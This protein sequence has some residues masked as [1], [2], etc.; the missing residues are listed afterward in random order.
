MY[1]LL[2]LIHF[3]YIIVFAG[4]SVSH[5]QDEILPCDLPSNLNI[6]T[7]T[8]N[9]AK[10]SW[11]NNENVQGWII[12]WRLQN[13]QYT[14][15]NNSGLIDTNFYE[16]TNIYPNS[17]YFF[18]IKSVC[19]SGESTWSNEYTFVTNLTNPS[20][21]SM[22]LPVKDPG[23]NNQTEKTYF[24][25][26]NSEFSGRSLGED[27]FIQK[28]N[29]I[30]DHDWTSD[31]EIKLTSPAGRSVFLVK[32]LNVNNLKGFGNPK[33]D[34]CLEVMSFSDDACKSQSEVNDRFV[35]DFLP[36]EQISGF[37]DGNS[38][39]G[40]WVIE[41]TDKVKI[42][43]GSLEYFDI[44]FAPVI[45]PIPSDIEIAPVD[46]QSIEIVWDQHV[47]VDTLILKLTK[48]NETRFFKSFNS[49]VILINDLMSDTEYQ[50]SLQSKCYNYISAYS[51]PKTIRTFCKSPIIREAFNE[52][53]MCEDPCLT[54]CLRSEFWFNDY[55]F[56]KKWLVNA[57]PTKTENTGP[58]QDVF[59]GGKYIY[60]E[61]SRGECELD[62]IATLQSVCLKVNESADGCDMSFFYHMYG[63]D[64]GSL[65]L[66]IS[67]NAG[68]SWSTLFQIHGNQGN[69]WH[70]KE[71]DL[72]TYKS[73]VCIFRF[74]GKV[75]ND[76]SFGDL[77]LDDITFF[78]CSKLV[79]SDYTF[80]P[81]HDND[82]YG[83][84]TTGLFICMP[85]VQNYV[86]NNKDCNDQN[87]NINPEATEI[88]CNFIDENCNGMSDDSGQD[89]PL[90]INLLEILNVSC[91]GKTDGKIILSVEDGLPPYNFLWSNGSTDSLLM[92]ASSGNYTCRIIDKT[93]CG[94]ITGP[95]FIGEEVN[96]QL[97]VT[98]L[99]HTQCKGI[100]S[101]EIEVEVNNGTGPYL[102]QWSN[103][104]NTKKISGLSPGFYS[105]TVTGADGCKVV[106][107]LIEIK[108]LASF[109]VG[110]NQMIEP[111]CYG[112]GNGTLELKVSGGKAPYKF[113]WNNGANDSKITGI[114]AGIYYCTITDADNCS[115]IEGP[116]KLN[117]PDE[118]KIKIT[119]IDNV[120][121]IGEENGSIEISAS[122]GK[123][124]YSF[125][126]ISHDYNDFVSFSDDIYNLRAGLYELFASDLNG[127]SVNLDN[128]EIKT[129]DSIEAFIDN[130]T[131]ASC[132]R[133]NEG[134]IAVKVTKGYQNYYY[135]WNNGG[136]ESSIDSL[137][138]GSYSVTVTDDL[139]CKFVINN[140]EVK[141]LDMPF[142]IELQLLNGIR[143][144]GKGDGAI[145]AYAGSDFPPFDFNWSAG[146]RNFT[147]QK[148]DSIINLNSGIYNVTVTDNAGCVGISENFVLDEPPEIEI[149]S[150]E[151]DEIL[152]YGNNSGS[153]KLEISGGIKPYS[154]SWN[155]G[156]YS[157]DKISKLFAG[158]YL[159]SIKDA[160]GCILLG[161][162]VN[163]GQP[164]EL[165]VKIVTKDAGKNQSNGEVFLLIEG[166]VS[167][168]EVVWDSNA[169]NQTGPH[170]FNL[171]KGWYS[172]T[173][174]DYNEC[175]K[176]LQ[177]Y[178]NENTVS[179]RELAEIDANIYPNPAS[180]HFVIEALS[181]QVK[182]AQLFTI[183]GKNVDNIKTEL[184]G[185]SGIIVFNLPPS[186]LYILRIETENST[187]FK[188]I[189]ITY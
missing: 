180:D 147:P 174:T 79:S 128:I 176:K 181:S 58:D 36:K 166:G 126:W 52:N 74:T 28:I 152:C 148:K 158:T 37:Y 137:A 144:N 7:I 19:S 175:E 55:R 62:T 99:K 46:D 109:T 93:G 76:R 14:D 110:I 156:A 127:C 68:I 143:C 160:N 187:D 27:V 154:I 12:K 132:A 20:S 163:I 81:D 179:T 41:I 2:K 49:G 25:I 124:P 185:E 8:L 105:V 32:S 106:S 31:I 72:Q 161:D 38:P 177:V 101:G 42:N 120:S 70:R 168:Y 51:C 139:G 13:G 59:G 48:D 100:S 130:I 18:R 78:S 94:M 162:S 155:N 145:R 117:Q 33:D 173:I 30:L 96:M 24:Y 114:K 29:L 3:F 149:S 39:E 164:N 186:G 118:F 64:I 178:I 21:C 113:F 141:S 182:A 44:S 87:K 67:E 150:I 57:G 125:Q 97:N 60:L 61:S 170:A 153:I 6:K 50:I 121:C 167:P 45:C 95:Y 88:K 1:N 56:D 135:Y 112:Y 119:S 35:G 104:M 159:P 66:E 15:S 54:D 131:D 91:K 77:A 5:G 53:E 26:Y 73:K 82:G 89:K 85:Q 103:L 184:F 80:Y 43:A 133:S 83:K 172:A 140:I 63:I 107:D 23:G 189:V 165:T 138:A 115:Q 142:D 108:A 183:Q 169:K 146:I 122:G 102:Y 9:S 71:I 16:L 84:D 22:N 157:G 129:I 69:H 11:K 34:E 92:N 75:K 136:N 111:S 123:I 4:L 151:V 90:K 86:K 47:L 40:I 134:L 65:S 17:K 171:A 10:I 188:K 116:I 98:T